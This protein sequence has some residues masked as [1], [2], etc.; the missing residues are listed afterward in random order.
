MHISSIWERVCTTAH[1][2]LAAICWNTWKERNDRIFRDTSH[3]TEI[4]PSIIYADMHDWIG[5]HCNKY[6]TR[7]L[8]EEGEDDRRISA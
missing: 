8:M 7:D 4:S 3:S 6:N 5:V 2:L 1:R